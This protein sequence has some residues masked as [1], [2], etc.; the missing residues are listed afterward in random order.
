MVLSLNGIPVIALELK[1]QLTGQNVR[2]AIRQYETSRSS[3]EF[4]FRFNHRFLAY[5]AADT[6]E[7]W[8]TTRL[9]DGETRFV[10]FNQGSNSPGVSG[11]AGNPA[12]P[13]GYPTSYLWER[14]LKRDSLLDLL[15]RFIVYVKKE[16][17]ILF[18]R[19]HQYDV[20]RKVLEIGK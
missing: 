1:D 7:V 14:V 2:D 13:D 18:P 16:N 11:G 10:P 6:C 19:Y 4:C 12:N 15:H 8:M 20:V 17:E 3:K 5:F 9:Q